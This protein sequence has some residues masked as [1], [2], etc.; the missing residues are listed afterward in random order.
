MKGAKNKRGRNFPGVHEITLT[1][2]VV[3]CEE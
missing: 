3:G 2:R 1:V